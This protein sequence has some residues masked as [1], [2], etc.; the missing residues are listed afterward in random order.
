MMF[1]EGEGEWGVAGLSSNFTCVAL[2]GSGLSSSGGGEVSGL[3]GDV[4]VTSADSGLACWTWRRCRCLWR[5]CT[6]R[7]REWRGGRKG[8]K[9][10]DAISLG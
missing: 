6:W 10:G 9:K 3:T 7:Y 1:S 5:P 4:G 2:R 8:R